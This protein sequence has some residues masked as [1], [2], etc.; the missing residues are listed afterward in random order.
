MENGGIITARPRHGRTKVSKRQ[1]ED[2]LL[3][4]SDLELKMGM[5]EAKLK[6]LTNDEP[7]KLG[8]KPKEEV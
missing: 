1:L 7:K 6:T 2:A 5:F 3:R 8:R 4:I